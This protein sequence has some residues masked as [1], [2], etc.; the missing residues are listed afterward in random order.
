MNLIDQNLIASAHDISEGG[1]ATCLTECC[2]TDHEELIGVK[3]D[4]APQASLAAHLFGEYPGRVVI[5]ASRE[6]FTN[7]ESMCRSKNIP[8]KKIGTVG[9]ERFS[10]NSVIDLSIDELATAYFNAI[11]NLMG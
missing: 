6:N 1:L 5:S 9:G 11:P 7:I 2:L 8:C 4:F 10:W 3:V